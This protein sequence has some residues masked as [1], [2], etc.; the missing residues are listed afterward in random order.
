MLENRPQNGS[1][2][3]LKHQEIHIVV[4]TAIPLNCEILKPSLPPFL[5][6]RLEQ[7]SVM[8]LLDA[9]CEGDTKISRHM[10]LDPM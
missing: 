8:S 2:T 7:K 6:I 4:M 10:L 1:K 5:I 9:D 3:S